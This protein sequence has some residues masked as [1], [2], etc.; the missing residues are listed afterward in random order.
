MNALTQSKFAWLMRREY[1]EHK[2][3]F[4]WAPVIV[5]A[6]MSF[7][8]LASLIGASIFKAKQGIRINGTH[9]GNLSEVMTPEQQADFAA[10]LAQGYLGTSAPLF[11]VLALV[12]FFFCLASMYDD[13][14]DRSVLFWK[15]LPI[16]DTATVMSK[17]AMALL[18]GPVITLVAA[19]LT[20]G[21]IA[22][23]VAV[24]GAF[25]GVN[26]FGVLLSTPD[27]YLA[28]F[29]VLAVLPVYI[30]W[31]LPTVG[32]LMLV[33]AWSRSKPFLWAVGTPVLSGVLISWFNAL[34]D[35]GWQ[36]EWFWAHIVGRGLLSVAPGS[37]MPYIEDAR[38]IQFD[39]QGEHL[40][41]LVAIS[42]Q[43]FSLPS[44]WIGLVAGAAMIYAA[45]RL[46]RYRDEG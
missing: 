26:M 30:A 43:A 19:T 32:W 1:W 35:M 20:S 37:W 29:K 31:A 21:L 11:G 16:S 34:F 10:G 25:H 13:R 33:S 41:Q 15:S 4:F 8:V 24:A 18:V 23:S 39:S 45:I 17:L 46:R 44:M 2:G 40:S 14:K 7:F 22:A 38:G 5:G 36:D 9:V 3:G 6:V 28:P 27:L 12:V 42:W